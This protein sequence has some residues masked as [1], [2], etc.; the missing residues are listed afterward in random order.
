MDVNG[1][2]LRNYKK[3]RETTLRDVLEGDYWRAAR[4]VAADSANAFMLESASEREMMTH[5]KNFTI[6]HR[7]NR[8]LDF[9]EDFR[10]KF[11]TKEYGNIEKY[12]KNSYSVE[13]EKGE[14]RGNE[15]KFF[16]VYNKFLKRLPTKDQEPFRKKEA[17]EIKEIFEKNSEN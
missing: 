11:L 8:D 5:T 14:M 15:D 10:K 3:V 9:T 17:K 12:Q 4:N 13:T 6:R 7:L 2:I 16:E 1:G